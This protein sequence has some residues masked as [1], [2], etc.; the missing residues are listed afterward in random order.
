MIEISSKAMVEALDSVLLS[1][2]TPMLVGSPGIGKSDIVKLVAKKIAEIKNVSIEHIM[3]HTTNNY[4]P[5]SPK[6]DL[7]AKISPNVLD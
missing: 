4:T 5:K 3:K 2:L 6:M 1:K 7:M